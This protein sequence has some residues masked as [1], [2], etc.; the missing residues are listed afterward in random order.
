MVLA[1]AAFSIATLQLPTVCSKQFDT[2]N[3]V[4]A[5]KTDT[6]FL[7]LLSEING[8]ISDMGF[9]IRRAKWPPAGDSPAPQLYLGFVNKEADESS[10][11]A[12]KYRTKDGKPDVRYAAFFRALLEKIASHPGDL[13]TGLGSVSLSD[14]L[15]CKLTIPEG[16]VSSQSA[17]QSQPQSQ[18]QLQKDLATF[19]ASDRQTALNQF[20]TDGW[21]AF[22]PSPDEGNRGY[23]LGPRS[24][25]EL[26]RVLEDMDLQPV[27]RQAF[28]DAILN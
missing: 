9:Q 17:A 22:D 15:N 11:K 25:L 21:L 20:V 23:C 4:F 3:Y 14:A 5:F 18:I 28:E 12:S 26:P 27:A 24:F 8:R 19:R 10:K 13:S 2:Q 1:T 6:G 16:L 7:T